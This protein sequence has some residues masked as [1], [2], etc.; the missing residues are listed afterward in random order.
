M[1]TKRLV[2]FLCLSILLPLVACKAKKCP[3]FDGANG[4][5]R[6]EYKKNGL[7]RKRN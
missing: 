3:A 6:I 7:V 5:K 4:G 2:I 1:Q